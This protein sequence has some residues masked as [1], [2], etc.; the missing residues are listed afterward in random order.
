MTVVRRRR[1]LTPPRRFGIRGSYV[2]YI[3]S[4]WPKAEDFGFPNEEAAFALQYGHGIGL[5][6]WEKPIISRLVSLEHPEPIE[7]GMSMALETFLPLVCKGGIVAFDEFNYDKFAG[8]T[9]AAKEVL[10]H[11]GVFRL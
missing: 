7:E 3:A 6:V 11:I 4:V 8:E 10:D 5:T 1:T 9:V 2:E